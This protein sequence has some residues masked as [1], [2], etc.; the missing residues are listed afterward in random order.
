MKKAIVTF[1]GAIL[2]LCGV[3]AG[4]SGNRDTRPPMRVQA[5]GEGL[6]SA[7]VPEDLKSEYALFAQRCSKCHSLSRALNNGD[8]DS[9]YWERYVTRMRRQPAS[10][11]A[12]EDE[13][14]ILR[15]LNYY[16]A[17]LRAENQQDAGAAQ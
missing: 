8:H 3:T 13:P 10:G 5:Q 2:V 17:Q 16:S 9:L 15:F 12:P 14:P 1:V 11:I 6:T 7:S 4:C